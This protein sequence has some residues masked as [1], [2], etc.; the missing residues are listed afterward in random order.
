MAKETKEKIHVK[1]RATFD[2]LLA[3]GTIGP[4][5]LV[6]IQDTNE[7]WT[8]GQFYS[9]NSFRTITDGTNQVSSNTSDG[10]LNLKG[11]GSISIGIGTAGTVTINGKSSVSPGENPGELCVD[12]QTVK[13]PGL[14][15]AAYTNTD[16]YATAEQGAKAETA[17][18]PNQAIAGGTKTKITYDSNG[19]VLAGADL[20][21][22]DIPVLPAE[23]ISGL[24]DAAKAGVHAEALTDDTTGDGL[25]TAGRVVKYVK[26]SLAGLTGVM[27]F[28]GALDEAPEGAE[29]TVA[30]KKVTAVAGDLVIVS[31]TSKEYVFDGTRWVEL[32][33]E[34]RYV[35]KSTTV[36][37][38]ELGS[39][40][41][42]EAL[43]K[44][45][46]AVKDAGVT[47][48]TLNGAEVPVNSGRV[49]LT[50]ATA[51]QGMRADSALQAI[52]GT[53]EG[54][55]KV[56]I[57]PVTGQAGAKTQEISVSLT[58]ATIASQEVPGATDGL[59]LASDLGA[60]LSTLKSGL[61]NSIT[62][63]KNGLA[64]I[65]TGWSEFE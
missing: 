40:I 6:F 16:R 33:D 12:G 18:Q 17:L 20:E 47:G 57:S 11:T 37:G 43:R 46:G 61:E 32:G 34:E 38:L 54:L 45:I 56:T 23:K 7:I 62:E 8:H 4:E 28:L 13:V 55:A 48:I 14:G 49:E 60:T 50:T 1:T 31:G 15:T 42:A 41:E 2:A 3:N 26:D 64:G 39:G 5:H 53:T 9:G 19:L 35:S 63:V 30:G 22:S 29:V 10:T 51:E 21:A 36:A 58:T 65:S 59:V 24:G 52:T 27:H 44:A 25:V